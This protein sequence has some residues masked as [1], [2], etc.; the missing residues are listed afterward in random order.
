MA[1]VI[2]VKA[3]RDFRSFKKDYEVTFDYTETDTIFFMG[4]NGCGKSTIIQAIRGELN[5]NKDAK[6]KWGARDDCKFVNEMFDVNID[7]FDKIYH[8]DIDGLDNA[9]SMFNACDASA[10]IE[11]G[12]WGM[13]HFSSGEKSVLYLARLRKDVMDDENSL[14]IFDEM[15]NHL[16]FSLRIK[17]S[18]WLNKIF[19]KSKKLIVTHD[20]L[21]ATVSE[22]DIV[23]INAERTKESNKLFCKVFGTKPVVWKGDDKNVFF[24]L[25]TKF[26]LQM[27]YPKNEDNVNNE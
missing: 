22:G 12:G 24:H 15:D 23:E 7:G 3:N 10:Y 6:S 25:L 5:S 4:I 18:D 16:D 9:Y 19:P 14:I 27:Q 11:N 26:G 17:F 13:Q 2:K 20:I 8:L 1:H 21:M